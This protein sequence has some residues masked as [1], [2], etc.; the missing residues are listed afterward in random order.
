MRLCV[1]CGSSAGRAPSYTAAARELGTL[2]ARR[3][4]DL[5]YGG[6]NVGLMG[7]VADATLAAGGHVIGVLPRALVDRELA[8]GGVEL[9][10]VASMHERKQLISQVRP[11]A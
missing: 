10:I 6:G 3:G 5:V 9:R 7:I 11:S 1:F 2:L 8:H 4:I